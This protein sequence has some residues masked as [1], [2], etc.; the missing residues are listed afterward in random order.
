MN[1][2]MSRQG[3]VGGTTYGGNDPGVDFNYSQIDA[4]A[5]VAGNASRAGAIG[6]ALNCLMP[7]TDD[8]LVLG[9]DHSIYQVQGDIAAGGQ[10]LAVSEAV[11]TL[12][13][14]CWDLDP[15]GTMYFVGTDGVYRMT[16]GS[17]PVN[18]SSAA[19]RDFFVSINRTTTYVVANWDRDRNGLWIHLTPVNSGATTHLFYDASG[20]G[21]FP[22]QYPVTNGPISAATFDGDGPLDRQLVLGGR[23]GY[24]RKFDPTVLVDDNGTASANISSYVQIGPYRPNG[25]A[26]LAVLEAL[27]VMLGDAP[28]GFSESQFQMILT[29]QSGKDALTAL[30][31]PTSSLSFTFIKQ[32]RRKR[33]LQ[34]I[35]GGSF[36]FKI[37]GVANKLWSLEKLVALF[38]DG[39]LQ[40]RY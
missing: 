23:D 3:I 16:V 26:A 30:T 11:G 12:G 39:G 2:V 37:A 35:S 15:T 38:T 31:V 29:I 27:E 25:D 24:I 36:F 18:I 10:I 21:F 14:D 40:R 28:A 13:P 33:L 32:S 7:W 9:G 19:I 1:F 5:A 20:G 22:L 17:Q 34:R 4:A 8:V 6:D